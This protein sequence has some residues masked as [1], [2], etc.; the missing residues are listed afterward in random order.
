MEGKR[1][2]CGVTGDLAQLDVDE[3][4]FS[5]GG[6]ANNFFEEDAAGRDAMWQSDV[7]SWADTEDWSTAYEG[8]DE[9]EDYYAD[10]QFDI[11]P[12]SMGERCF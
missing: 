8:D 2:L 1:D 3:V 9:L 5:D 11:G 10:E 7:G 12:G 4:M 6:K